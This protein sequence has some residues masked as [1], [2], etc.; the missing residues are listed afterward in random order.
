MILL[1]MLKKKIIMDYC[2]IPNSLEILLISPQENQM[3]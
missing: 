1:L 2:E 3:C